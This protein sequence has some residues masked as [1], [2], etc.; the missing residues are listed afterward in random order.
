MVEFASDLAVAYRPHFRVSWR[1]KALWRASR[2]RR[3]RRALLRQVLAETSDP[4]LIE[5]AGM[6]VPTPS[7]LELFARALLRHRP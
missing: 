5:E 6:S 2:I 3:T 4:R 7:G 1:L